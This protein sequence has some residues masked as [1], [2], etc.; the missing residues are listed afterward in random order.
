MPN[1][2][3]ELELHHA[4]TCE[5][6]SFHYDMHGT[7]PQVR[8]S[9]TSPLLQSDDAHTEIEQALDAWRFSIDV[10]VRRVENLLGR[11]KDSVAL[12]LGEA[13]SMKPVETT[14]FVEG[15]CCPSEVPLIENI[16][17]PRRT[18]IF[19]RI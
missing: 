12:D 2:E 6:G 10:G 14:L 17:S 13:V 18:L 5:D 8:M 11:E 19:T 15:I 16:L 4:H 1:D 3:G 9:D 7:I